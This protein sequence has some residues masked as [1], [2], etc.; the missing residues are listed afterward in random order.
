[1]KNEQKLSLEELNA[2]AGG[3]N[4]E[5]V[6]L[7]NIL[8]EYCGAQMP[9]TNNEKHNAQILAHYFKQYEGKIRVTLYHGINK[10]NVY[11]VNRASYHVG[12]G[13]TFGWAKVDL[14]KL[15]ELIRNQPRF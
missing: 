12:D 2:V 3:N 4:R 11:E 13:L 10:S 6:Q 14:P 1:M 5:T 8:T 15:V 9:P 7:M